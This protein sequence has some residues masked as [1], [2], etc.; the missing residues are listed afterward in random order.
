M[1]WKA[2]E[3]FLM[4]SIVYINS[5]A[6]LSNDFLKQNLLPHYD[7]GTHKLTFQP[8]KQKISTKRFLLILENFVATKIKGEQNE[9]HFLTSILGTN[10]WF[11]TIESYENKGL[12]FFLKEIENPYDAEMFEMWLITSLDRYCLWPCKKRNNCNS[13]LSKNLTKY[14][15]MK[16]KTF[17]F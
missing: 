11:S 8:K 14:C 5:E 10:N 2:E 16:K 1:W 9:T 13:F 15:H 4:V 6:E 17:F 3:L 7:I 12:F